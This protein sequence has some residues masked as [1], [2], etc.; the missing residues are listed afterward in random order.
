MSSDE[1]KLRR[2]F[3]EAVPSLPTPTDR[4]A[5]IGARVQRRRL[6]VGAAAGG[7]ALAVALI[8]GLSAGVPGVSVDHTPAGEGAVALMTV[9]ARTSGC[10]ESPSP[11]P[12]LLDGVA[13]RLRSQAESRFRDS[14]AEIEITDRVRVFRKPSAELDAWVLQ[15]FSA[16]CVELVDAPY[17]G[18]EIHALRDRINADR[19]YWLRQG[20]ALNT[21]TVGVDGT[22]TIG[23]GE[24][25]KEKAGAAV[26]VRY[27][28]RVIVHEQGPIPPAIGT[29]EP[30]STE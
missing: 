16:D 5:S 23:V 27:G 30:S 7:T 20:I 14:F 6:A 3:Q 12:I 1:E 18:R 26:P 19:D 8:V 2:F 28:T 25:Q 10:G 13:N 29:V 9:S 21:V 17:S 24:G 15:E 11:G 22:I 4:M